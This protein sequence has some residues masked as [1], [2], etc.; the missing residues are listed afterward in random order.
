MQVTCHADL[1]LKSPDHYKDNTPEASDS[2]DSTQERFIADAP[3]I[4]FEELNNIWYQ[5]W[6]LLDYGLVNL[7]NPEE[8]IHQHVLP[9][10][11]PNPVLPPHL[12]QQKEEDSD[13]E[14][15]N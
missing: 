2:E 3:P 13:D 15:A 5:I 11:A 6:D 8:P 1:S 14:M 12:P 10:F 4:R 7:F 9:L